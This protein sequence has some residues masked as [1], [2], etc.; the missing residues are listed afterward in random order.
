[1]RRHNLE[2]LADVLGWL[3]AIPCKTKINRSKGRDDNH[4]KTPGKGRISFGATGLQFVG[5]HNYVFPLKCASVWMN[6]W[7]LNRNGSVWDELLISPHTHTHTHTH[8][9]VATVWRQWSTRYG[10]C[11]IV[12]T[13]YL[14]CGWKEVFWYR[15]YELSMETVQWRRTADRFI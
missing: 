11:H 5:S 9:L 10:G 8:I 14:V 6:S 1:M 3:G 4:T 7:T 15:K 12:L 2:M 13:Y